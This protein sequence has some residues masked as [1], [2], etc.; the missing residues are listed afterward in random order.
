MVSGEPVRT[1][2]WAIAAGSLVMAPIGLAQLATADL[3]SLGPL[4][5]VGLLYSS[6]LAVAVANVVVFRAIS[7]VGPTRIANFQFLVPAMAVGFAAV[8]LDEAILPA[9]VVGGLAIVS[10]IVI[11]RRGSRLP[12]EELLESA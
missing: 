10:G 8:F 9:Q 1:T 12:A 2:A 7:L 3:S 5:F 4:P 6:L 11:A